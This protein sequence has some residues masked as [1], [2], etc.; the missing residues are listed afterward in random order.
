[1]R[2]IST[3]LVP[4]SDTAGSTNPFLMVL[5][6]PSAHAPFIPAPQYANE[7]ANEKAPRTPGK[8]KKSWNHWTNL[9]II[10]C[11]YSIQLC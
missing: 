1:M 3:I 5:A 7:F 6:T 9:K 11:C 4:F 10:W 8:L 2:E